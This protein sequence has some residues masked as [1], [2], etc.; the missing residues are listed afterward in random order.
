MLLISSHVC[1][2]ILYHQAGLIWHIVSVWRNLNSQA[3]FLSIHWALGTYTYH[4]SITERNHHWFPD[5]VCC[6]W[7][8][9]GWII[10]SWTIQNKTQWNLIK[11][12]FDENASENCKGQL[13]CFAIGVLRAQ[14]CFIKH[15]GSLGWSSGGWKLTNGVFM[16][17]ICVGDDYI[18]WTLMGFWTPFVCDPRCSSVFHSC[19]PPGGA[20][21]AVLAYQLWPDNAED[22]YLMAPWVGGWLVT[23]KLGIDK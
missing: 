17:M 11:N 3:R 9:Q 13:I 16:V 23:W 18:L 4:I 6:R 20:V 7:L 5:M 8:N 1:F 14:A 2:H 21:T 19:R 15:G 12:I 10:F 22:C